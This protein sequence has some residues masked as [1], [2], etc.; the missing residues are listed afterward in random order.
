[1]ASTGCTALLPTIVHQHTPRRCPHEF[2][3]Y[4]N[5]TCGCGGDVTRAMRRGTWE[6]RR[7]GQYCRAPVFVTDYPAAIKPFYARMNEPED[8][9]K[10]TSTAA[11]GSTVASFDLLVPGIGELVGGSGREE[12]PDVLENLLH[13]HGAVHT[14]HAPRPTTELHCTALHSTA[15]HCTALHRHR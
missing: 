14:P 15:Q 1:M 13:V 4:T 11:R 9:T 12:R 6:W 3:I 7:C 10:P 5:A 2:A 8:T